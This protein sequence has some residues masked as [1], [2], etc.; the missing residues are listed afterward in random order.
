[1]TRTRLYLNWTAIFDRDGPDEGHANSFEPTSASTPNGLKHSL[2]AGASR[3]VRTM[4][5]YAEVYFRAHL[6]SP[7][8]GSPRR[9]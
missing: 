6:E 3:T 9:P 7:P 2:S 1:M 5:R 8:R 4:F